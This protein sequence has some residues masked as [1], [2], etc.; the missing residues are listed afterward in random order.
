MSPKRRSPGEGALYYI[1]DRDLWRG[2][3]DVDPKPDGTRQQRT[4]YGKT[5]V[6]AAAKLE[7]L[8]TGVPAVCPCCRRPY[9]DKDKT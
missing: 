1:K 3:I 8:K 9:N 5:E 6:E 7:A 2:V 4:V